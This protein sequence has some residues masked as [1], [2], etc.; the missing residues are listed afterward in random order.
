MANIISIGTP[1]NDAEREAIAYLRDHLP[2]N[3]TVIHNF[4]LAQGKDIVEIDLAVLTPH[5]VYLVDVKGVHGLIDVYGTRWYPEGRESYHSP[6]AKGRLNAKLFK[7]FL[8]ESYPARIEMQRVY[9]RAAVLLTA[10]DARVIDHGSIDA[11]DIVRLNKSAVYFKNQD[12]V[13]SNMSTTIGPQ[14]SQIESAIKGKARPRSATPIYRDWQVDE[15]L[16]GNERYTEY[17]AHHLLANKRSTNRL[18]VYRADPY[19][20]EEARKREQKLI[21]NAFRTLVDVPGHPNILNVRDFFP[22]EDESYFVLVTEDAQ[23]QMLRQYLKKATLTL[24]FDQKLRVIRDVLIGLAHVHAHGVV[25]RDLTPDAIVISADGHARLSSFEYARIG[26][27]NTSSIAQDIVDAVDQSYQ[28]PECYGDPAQATSI[29]DLFSAGLIFYELLTG[30]P[31][32][33][34]PTQIF[35]TGAIFPVPLTELKPDLPIELNA[36]LQKLCVF[37][38]SARFANATIALRALSQAITPAQAT[39][40]APPNVPKV[41]PD[42]QT[43]DKRNLPREYVLSERFVVQERLGQGGFAV[44]YKV[45]DTMAEVMRVFKLV[46]T[47][48]ISVY[49]RLRQEYKTLVSLPE[50]PYVVKVIWADRLADGTPYIVFEY[51]DGLNVEELVRSK[52]VSL[53]DAVTIAKQVAEGLLHLHTHG[54]YHQDIKPSNLLWTDQGIRIIDFNVALSEQGGVQMAGGTIRYIPPDLEGS[55][56]LSSEQKIERDVYAL[57]VTFYECVTGRYP[58]EDTHHRR[59]AIDPYTLPGCADL[60]PALVTLLLK[61]IAPIATE[62]FSTAASLLAALNSL[63]ALRIVPEPAS[64]PIQRQLVEVQRPNTN[65]FVRHLLSLYSQSQHTNAGTR[66]LDDLGAQTYVKTFLDK[67]LGPAILRGDFQLV[68][69]SGNA[70]DGKTAFIQ[71]MAK[72]A[73]RAGATIQHQTNGY[74]FI[75]HGRT[76]LSNYDGSQDEGEQINDDVL[77]AFLDPFQGMDEAQWNNK[78]TRLIAINEGRLID[79]LTE[80]QQHFPRLT[81][82]AREGLNGVG[83]ASHVAIINL[84]LRSV[85]ATGSEGEPSIFDRLLRRMLNQQFWQPCESCD[86]KQRCYIYHNTRTLMDSTAGAK[87]IER[88]KTL[89]TI[90]HLRGQL[91]VTLRDLR[92]ALAYMLVGTRDCDDVHKLYNEGTSTS[93]Q[94]ILDGFYFNAW[95]GG[96][97]PTQDRLIALLREIDVGE[98]SNAELDRSFDFLEPTAR[99]MARFSYANRASYDDMLLEKHF[100]QLSREYSKPTRQK[101]IEQHRHY[102]AMLRRRHYF[103]CRDESWQAMLPY[104]HYPAFLALI[105]QTSDSIEQV[106]ILLQAINRGE[107]LV[108]SSKLVDVLALRVRQ[109]ERGTIQSYRLFNGA[110]FRLNRRETGASTSFVEYLPQAIHLNYQSDTNQE[111]DLRINLDIYEMLMR[112]N[113]GYRPSPEEL[114][115]FY[116]SLTIFKNVLSSASYQEVLLTETGHEFYKVSRSSNGRLSLTQ[117]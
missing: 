5:C 8:I 84:N 101:S 75:L 60:H 89:Y 47:D 39:P 63:P 109:V 15:K 117:I 31:A 97:Y 42:I 104:R 43:P 20:D 25:H 96:T 80:H 110:Y 106:P 52:A 17:R 24:T 91:H 115:G 56:D 57:G 98:V 88:L 100:R 44:A 114:Q 113:S 68:I 78:E 9:V 54:V 48:H 71:Q 13:P 18:R 111:A 41:A 76:F 85:V 4:E 83:T 66:G 61:A 50:H 55:A 93:I 1:R 67:Q 16:G 19:Q 40:Q 10:P 6:L 62:R 59:M 74:T 33:T 36:W 103:E 79:F 64:V 81:E 46:L 11:D 70:G 12:N 37:E 112:L 53:E 22:A 21:S 72:N 23:G 32:F 29:S 7:A 58:F 38:P 86:L 45:F 34:G 108:D 94:Q 26:T 87:T 69:I 2:A 51:I 77:L 92:S 95:M 35:D 49:Q 73:E 30:E 116:L 102:V 27:R 3:Y 82:L 99:E 90:T 107:G 14:L 65:P 28:A 105:T